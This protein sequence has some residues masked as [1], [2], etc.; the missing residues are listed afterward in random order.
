MTAGPAPRPATPAKPARPAAARQPASTRSAPIHPARRAVEQALEQET[1][2]IDL[3]EPMGTV[4]LPSPHR[5]AF[6]G[7]IT[8]L[9]VFGILDWPVVVV[10]GIGHLLAED[11]HHKLLADFGS[12]LAEA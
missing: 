6:Y 2:S 10:I 4:R 3:P 12:A 5:L 8:A 1:I 9:G 11:R 7:G